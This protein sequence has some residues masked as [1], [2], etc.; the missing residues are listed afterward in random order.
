MLL[1]LSLFLA[2]EVPIPISTLFLAFS[3]FTLVGIASYY[4]ISDYSS[5]TW[6]YDLSYSLSWVG[7][8]WLL[9]A[10][11]LVSLKDD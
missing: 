5:L 10:D 8:Y 3:L 9:G 1:D 11:F 4:L 6:F 2:F 7:Y